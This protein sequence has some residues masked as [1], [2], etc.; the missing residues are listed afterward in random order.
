MTDNQQTAASSVDKVKWLVVLAIITVG[1]LANQ[2]YSHYAFSLRLIG[3]IV[4]AAVVL[5]LAATT[6]KGKK[7]RLFA[8]EA[9]VEMRKVVWPTRQETIQ[10]TFIVMIMV[11]IVALFLW[12]LDSLLLVIVRWLMS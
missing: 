12:G 8:K 6:A 2:Y 7:A 5:G 1:V 10:T 9:R 4:L 11:L 3:W